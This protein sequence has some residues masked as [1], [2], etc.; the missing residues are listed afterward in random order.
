LVGESPDRIMEE[1]KGE[2]ERKQMMFLAERVYL[3][4]VGFLAQR[5]DGMMGMV[6]NIRTAV[7]ALHLILKL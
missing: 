4:M 3:L 1:I 7:K 2:T 5:N 6:N